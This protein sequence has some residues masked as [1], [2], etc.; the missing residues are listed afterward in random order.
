MRL[1][2]VSHT[3]DAVFGVLLDFIGIPFAVTAEL[4]WKGNLPQI[5]CVPAGEYLCKRIISP[6]FGETFEMQGVEN[7][8]HILFHKGNIALQDSKG[9]ILIG[10]QFEL[11]NGKPGILQSGKGFSEFMAK[12]YYHDVFNL[13]IT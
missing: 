2:R 9:C 3:E 12:L 1:I 6:K 11:V 7:R 10:E 4:P 13:V 8:S 5:S